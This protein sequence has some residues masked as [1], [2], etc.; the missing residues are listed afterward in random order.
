MILEV[1]VVV[2]VVTRVITSTSVGRAW[3]FYRGHR[4]KK[5][6]YYYSLGMSNKPHSSFVMSFL[7]LLLS[8]FISAF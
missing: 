5:L 4:L 1:V 6:Q 7:S 2:A 8:D 3:I